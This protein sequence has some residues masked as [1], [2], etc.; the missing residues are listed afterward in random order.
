LI[1]KVIIEATAQQDAQD[2]A[3]YIIRESRGTAPAKKWLSELEAAI[4]MLADMPRR[5]RVIDEQSRFPMELRQFIHYSHR[6]IYHINEETCTV[7]VLRVYH[8][9]RDEIQTD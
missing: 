2:Y 1:Y 4:E 7:H 5:F 6:V 9:R 3:A 8:G